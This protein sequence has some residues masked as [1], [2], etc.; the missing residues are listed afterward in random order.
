MIPELLERYPEGSDITVMNTYYQYPLFKQGEGKIC[1][2]F[3][4]L[5]YK[6]NT[7]GQKDYK[8]IEKPKYTYYKLKDQSDHVDYN[9]LFIE[10]SKVEPVEVTFTDLEK[11]IAETTGNLDFYKTNLANRER[12]KNK[13]L[14]THTDIFFSDANIV[15]SFLIHMKTILENSEKVSSI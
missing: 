12:A 7:T 2:D 4:V 1:D 11:D 14:H 13:R 15:L 10:R 8:I 3:L 5:T 6:D 9:R